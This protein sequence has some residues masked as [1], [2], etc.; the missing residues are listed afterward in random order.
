M[1][2]LGSASYWRDAGE[3]AGRQ[4]VGREGMHYQESNSLLT[5]FGYLMS[6]MPKHLLE[7]LT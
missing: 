1:M 2:N 7:L 5:Y 6:E 4:D 3:R